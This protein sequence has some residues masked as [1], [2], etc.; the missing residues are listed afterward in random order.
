[1]RTKTE[2]KAFA[3]E[4]RREVN[5]GPDEPFDAYA[6]AE[7][8]GVPVIS[9]GSSGCSSEALEHF[10]TTAPDK[11]SGA[12]VPVDT[13]TL[14]LEND[15]HPRERRLSTMSHELSH[16][17]LEH[18]FADAVF[19]DRRKCSAFAKD[20]ETEAAELGGELLVPSVI[21]FQLARANLSDEAVAERFEVS[22]DMARW[23]M[24]STGARKAAV[25]RRRAYERTIR[26]ESR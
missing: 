13:G 17:T 18:E 23:R 8:Y 3:L 21:A 10:L 12:L 4:L 1:M 5:Q 15:A 22:V 26:G 2:L 25:N 20:Q 16:L 6:L 7:L 11:F 24:N 9:I 19:V 14:I